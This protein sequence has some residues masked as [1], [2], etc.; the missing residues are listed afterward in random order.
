MVILFAALLLLEVSPLRLEDSIILT[1]SFTPEPIKELCYGLNS[2]KLNN[3]ALSS[4]TSLMSNLDFLFLV[5]FTYSQSFNAV[6]NSISEYFKVP[7]LSMFKS[8]STF[9][10]RVELHIDIETEANSILSLV[11]ALKLTS[12]TIVTSPLVRDLELAS[13]LKAVTKNEFFAY[14][15]NISNEF[16]NNFV[17]KILKTSG[18]KTVI[19]I[20]SSESFSKF[21]QALVKKNWM[22]SGS[23]VIYSSRTPSKLKTI[24][25][26]QVCESGTEDFSSVHEFHF[27]AVSNFV[28]VMSQKLEKTIKSGELTRN[29]LLQRVKD[30][31]VELNFVN[32]QPEIKV[33]GNYNK[34]KREV[35]ITSNLIFPG[36]TSDF[37]LLKKSQILLSI[38]NGTHDPYYSFTYEYLAY[39]YQGANYAVYR[40]NLLNEIPNFELVLSPNDCG[41]F[42]YE[43]YWYQSCFSP[44]VDEMGIGFIT[45][46][47]G[48]AIKGNAYTLRGLN[49]VIPQVSPLGTDDEIESSEKFP[50]IVKLEASIKLY[51]SSRFYTLLTL[52]YKDL[53]IIASNDTRYRGSYLYAKELI[54]N[55]GLKIVNDED[56][57]FVDYKY[58]RDNFTVY[59]ALFKRIKNTYCTAFYILTL[60]PEYIL[61]ALYDVGLRKGDFVFFHDSSLVSYLT[62]LEEP[63]LTK[64]KELIQGT[65]VFSYREWVGPLGSALQ[66]ELSEKYSELTYMCMTYDT[67]SVFKEA[68]KYVLSIGED[69]ENYSILMKAIRFNRFIG[70]LGNV[71]FTS[72]GNSRSSAQL[73]IQQIYYNDSMNILKTEDVA[74]YDRFGSQ[75]ITQINQYLW[76]NGEKP[77]NY[78]PVSECGFE[79]REEQNSKEGK[80]VL[81]VI[82]AVLFVASVISGVLCIWCYKQKFEELEERKVISLGDM[83]F[84]AFFALEFFQII[85]MGPD[86]DAYT[87]VVGNLQILLSLDL[88]SFFSFKFGKFWQLFYGIF[89][90]SLT[91]AILFIFKLTKLE[92]LIP[93]VIKNKCQF[94]ANSFLL[95]IGHLLFLPIVSMLLNIFSCYRSTGDNLTDSFLDKDCKKNCYTGTHKSFAICTGLLLFVFIS[96]GTF[97]RPSLQYQN[98]DQNVKTKSKFIV[99]QTWIQLA[100][101]ILNKTLKIE[102]QTTHGIVII[103]VLFGYLVGTYIMKPYNFQ[104]PLIGHCFFIIGALWATFTSVLFREV[105]SITVWIVVE[106]AG[107]ALISIIGMIAYKR[108]TEMLYSVKGKDI[109]TL[110]LFQCLKNYEKYIKDFESIDFLKNSKYQIGDSSKLSS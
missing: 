83:I 53:I 17:L 82:C 33:V 94:L 70:C 110:F 4:A 104:R 93:D 87:Q 84:F 56:S 95:I 10:N 97:Y 2:L 20:D 49:K 31:S 50:E 59:E 72:G 108:S 96:L 98:S 46:F 90:V 3:E 63:Y 25:T 66:K 92:S 11:S 7:Y 21:E 13:Y 54:E 22:K 86:Q 65:L 43:P 78:R 23:I 28:Q 16:A 1:S 37:N 32:F 39:L 60:Y 76:P 57:R 34:D 109:S 89:S 27:N 88:N 55:I 81:Y 77:P 71:F 69:I 52:G 74:Y 68:I 73:L 100:L 101:V 35:N 102:N 14:S 30:F 15:N 47:F 26:L 38:A 61:E 41:M 99:F 9:H 62:N 75:L 58:T 6:V 64:R 91:C 79:P 44:L 80:K 107:L 36:N 85:I 51:V 105:G 45:S 40:S 48:D 42:W 18:V 8:N 12:F 24:G 67:V 19:L 103:I 29:V 106:F 5:D